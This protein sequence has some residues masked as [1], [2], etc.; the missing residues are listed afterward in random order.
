MKN[1]ISI[2]L[3]AAFLMAGLTAMAGSSGNIF[4]ASKTPHYLSTTGTVIS[5]EDYEGQDGWRLVNITDENG[6]P[7]TLLITDKTVFPFASEFEVGD[8]VTGYY[9]AD[10]PMILIWPPQ[11]DTAILVAGIPEGKTAIADRFYAMESNPDFMLSQ[12]GQLAFRTD[13]NTEIVLANGDDFSDGEIEGRRM[14]VIYGPFVTASY[15][16]QATATKVIVLYEDAVPLSF[17][18]SPDVL[19]DTDVDIDASGWPIL[20]NGDKI[21]A[22]D[23]FRNE[24]GVLMVPVRAIAEKLGYDVTWDGE[25]RS[26]R[27]GVVINLW[28]GK[29]EVHIGRMAPLSISA[30]PVIVNGTTFVPLDFFRNILNVPNAIAFEG[31]IE[32]DTNNDRME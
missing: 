10:A 1:V 12:S 32:I 2:I 19:P 30:A 31:Q 13:E 25:M 3:T 4:D 28:I 5:V 8:V 22:P 27:L 17:A 24:D 26:V 20:V 11:Y 7:A 23:A 14:V 21:D 29:N 6:N 16:A 9:L 15:P 18:I